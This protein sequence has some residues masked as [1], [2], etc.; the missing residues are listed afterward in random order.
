MHKVTK[1]HFKKKK[2]NLAQPDIYKNVKV[3][4][5]L[6]K[7]RANFINLMKADD[8][9][10]SV[11]SREVILFYEWKTD[12]LAYK[13]HGVYEGGIDLSYGIESVL[14]CFNSFIPQRANLNLQAF[15]QPISSNDSQESQNHSTM[16]SSASI[17]RFPDQGSG[18]SPFFPPQYF[19]FDTKK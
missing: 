1:H 13:I 12:S 6:S 11:L 18:Q 17:F 19:K 9:I 14:N 10:N 5:D 15:R 16:P 7:A 3:F 2:R 8:G 4:D